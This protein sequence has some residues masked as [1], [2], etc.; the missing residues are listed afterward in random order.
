M[1]LFEQCLSS[2]TALE[3]SPDLNLDQR[4]DATVDRYL[5]GFGTET[6]ATRKKLAEAFDA[7]APMTKTRERIKDRI[8]RD[9]QPVQ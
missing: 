9:S 4:I 7:K 6:A 8:M 5:V 1:N 3:N 2:L